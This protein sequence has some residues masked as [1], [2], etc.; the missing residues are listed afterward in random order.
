MVATVCVAAAALVYP[1]WVAGT[2]IA[3]MSGAR[4]VGVVVLV[5]GLVA[6]VVAVVFGAGEGLPGPGSSVSRSRR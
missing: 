2:K 5:L 6:S 4:R 3:G 1:L